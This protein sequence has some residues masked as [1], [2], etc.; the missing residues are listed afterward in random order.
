MKNKHYL[1]FHFY[2]NKSKK[3]NPFKH[4]RFSILNIKKFS[5]YVIFGLTSYIIY[6]WAIKIIIK[7]K[8]FKPIH[9]EGFY[10]SSVTIILYRIYVFHCINLK[11]IFF[12]F[13]FYKHKINDIFRYSPC[14]QRRNR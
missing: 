12:S 2:H 14:I 11:I 4:L 8:Y 10:N 3:I 1:Q 13:F 7:I 6:V 5:P 9:F